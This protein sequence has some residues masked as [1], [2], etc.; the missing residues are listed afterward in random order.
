M[1]RYLISV[2][3]L[4]LCTVMN[5]PSESLAETKGWEDT[6]PVSQAVNFDAEDLEGNAISLQDYAGENILLVFFTTW[7]EVCQQELPMLS[8]NYHSLQSEGIEVLAINMT[9]SERNETDIQPFA[10]ELEMPVV[11]DRD[12]RISKSYGVKGIPTTYA[13]DKEQQIIQTFF[14]PL[15]KNEVLQAF[16]GE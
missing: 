16:E 10:E 4:F 6:I 7:C 9:A 13:V 3:L 11:I 12:G 15:N 5:M 8:E 14:G 2:I 1:Q